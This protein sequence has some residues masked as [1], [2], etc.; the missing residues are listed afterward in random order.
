MRAFRRNIGGFAA[1]SGAA[2]TQWTNDS[3]FDAWLI[4]NI[5]QVANPSLA[6]IVPLSR[7]WVIYRD[8]GVALT[9]KGRDRESARGFAAFLQSPEGARIFRTWGWMAG[10]VR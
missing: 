7:R 3:S 8:A 5:W 1:N 6:D 2:K 4:W 10:S 9:A